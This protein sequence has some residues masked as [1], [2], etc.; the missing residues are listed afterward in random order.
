MREK[1]WQQKTVA[2]ISETTERT[3]SRW[4]RAGIKPAEKTI[5]KIAQASGYN[6]Y[7]LRD[8]DYDG[9]QLESA[10]WAHEAGEKRFTHQELSGLYYRIEE[11]LTAKGIGKGQLAASAGLT[12]QINPASHYWIGHDEGVPSPWDI[13]KIAAA[14]GYNKEWIWHGRG[15]RRA[16]ETK[17]RAEQQ[18]SAQN[19]TFR[20]EDMVAATIRILKSDTVYR[21]ALASNIRAFDKAVLME[22]KMQGLEDE[23]RLLREE[24]ATRDALAAQRMDR[25][26]QLVLS[27]G[28][29]LPEKK[30]TAN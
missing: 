8:D 9:P 28:G 26:E 25:L 13:E 23:M 30:R 2:R 17:G 4:M 1:G 12:C 10:R 6:F 18:E 27:L 19:E 5:H 7:W 21:S 11:I 15:P 24:A 29:Q 16:K 3:V 22:G 20:L 14:T